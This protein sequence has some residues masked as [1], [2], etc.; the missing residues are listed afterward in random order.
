[1]RSRRPTATCG[2]AGGVGMAR[3][4]T[5]RRSSAMS[6]MGLLGGQ[7]PLIDV[8]SRPTGPF[9]GVGRCGPVASAAATAARRPR[10]DRHPPLGGPWRRRT[11]A[12]TLR[13]KTCATVIHYLC[14]EG[15]R[16]HHAMPRAAA[17]HVVVV[18]RSPAIAAVYHGRFAIEGYRVTS[19]SDAEPDPFWVLGLGPDL[20]LLD[21]RWGGGPGGLAFLRR[22]RREPAGRTAPVV[23]STP[24]A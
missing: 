1:M 17:P 6:R 10:R 21:L 14:K 16:G 5:L 22:L 11:P 7:G 2:R 13:D 19:V 4:R 20:V 23:C 24:V 15:V 9:G 3:V 12:A 8:V 18:D